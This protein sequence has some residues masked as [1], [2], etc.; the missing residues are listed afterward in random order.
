VGME[1]R[2]RLA[3]GSL[4]IDTA[5]GRGTEVVAILPVRRAG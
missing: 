2:V 3:R 1:E 4:R 5:P